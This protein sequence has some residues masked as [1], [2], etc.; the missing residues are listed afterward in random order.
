MIFSMTSMTFSQCTFL[1]IIIFS[2]GHYNVHFV[3][4]TMLSIW[5]LFMRY[6]YKFITLLFIVYYFFSGLINGLYYILNLYIIKPCLC[7]N[8]VIDFKTVKGTFASLCF[9]VWKCAFC[10]LLV[11][12]LPKTSLWDHG[13]PMLV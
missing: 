13:Y 3:H 7:V 8:S 10:R 4:I 1:L 11:V 2:S 9:W 6:R 5:H 12:Y